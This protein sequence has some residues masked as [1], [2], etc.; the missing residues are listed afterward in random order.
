MPRPFPLQLLEVK[1]TPLFCG[2]KSRS[3]SHSGSFL[4]KF[5]NFIFSSHSHSQFIILIS[6]LS[7][8]LYSHLNFYNFY[9]FFS[10]SISFFCFMSK[11]FK[12]FHLYLITF[13]NF[14]SGTVILQFT[15]N[16]Y[17]SPSVYGRAEEK[18][19]IPSHHK[20]VCG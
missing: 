19:E 3:F 1:A 8:N 4:P 12:Y 5:L 9:Q 2:Y 6:I 16:S 18:G 14:G 11:V 17:W 7:F 13:D 10:T 20:G 15:E